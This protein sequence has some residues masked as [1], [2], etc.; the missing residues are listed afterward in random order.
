MRTIGFLCVLALVAGCSRPAAVSQT[1]TASASPTPT[2][3]PAV[4]D[5]TSEEEGARLH[6]DWN[7]QWYTPKSWKGEG[8]WLTPEGILVKYWLLSRGEKGLDPAEVAR[9]FEASSGM[10]RLKFG[11]AP[12]P[13]AQ[14]D[15]H[16]WMLRGSGQ[17]RNARHQ[18]EPVVWQ[19]CL[20]EPLHPVRV[21]G[22]KI[23]AAFGPPGSEARCAEAL[24][25]V[26]RTMERSKNGASPPRI[27]VR[28]TPN[29]R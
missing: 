17:K 25:K 2:G 28:F 20:V 26:T 21:S 29:P 5:W 22:H 18:L 27:K 24:L 16:L 1:P 9:L 6:F 14:D 13:V 10:T 4:P 7:V 3:T 12:S 15:F 11:E 19:A 23:F 8:R